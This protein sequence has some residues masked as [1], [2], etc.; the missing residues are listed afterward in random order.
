MGNNSVTIINNGNFIFDEWYLGSVIIGDFIPNEIRPHSGPKVQMTR[1]SIINSDIVCVITIPEG[2]KLQLINGTLI[3][4]KAL[5][6]KT[7]VRYFY[8]IGNGTYVMSMETS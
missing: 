1:T 2:S 4:E 8:V 6:I 7:G 3:K 5:N